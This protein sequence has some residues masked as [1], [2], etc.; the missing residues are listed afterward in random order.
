MTITVVCD[1]CALIDLK[2]GQLQYAMMGLPYRFVVPEEIVEKEILDFT[3]QELRRLGESGL[4]VHALSESESIQS[5]DLRRQNK[6]LSMNDCNVLAA[7]LHIL[8]SVLLTGD[9]A[10]RIAAGSHGIRVH[11]VLWIVDELRINGICGKDIL[12]SAL[13]I[14]R[15]NSSVFL[16]NEEIEKRLAQLKKAN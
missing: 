2:K 15:D 8:D 11:G 3:P 1:S 5:T 10:L 14:W 6:R 7:S 13:K 4:D 16:P 12:A 9:K